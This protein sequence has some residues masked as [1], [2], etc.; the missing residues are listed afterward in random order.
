MLDELEIRLYLTRIG[1][2][3][4]FT[5]CEVPTIERL[6]ELQLAHLYHVPF[7]NLSITLKQ[8]IT[9]GGK[10]AYHKIVADNR[11]GF[12]Y[13]L[14]YAFYQLLSSLHFKVQMLSA[15]V[16]DHKN[17]T[18]GQPFDHL[19]LLVSFH[20]QQYLVDVGFG[21]SFIQPL[22]LS[23]E[24]IQQEHSIY[25][26]TKDNSTYYLSRQTIGEPIKRQ[27]RFTVAPRA[28]EDFGEMF[29]YHQTNANSTFT[30]KSVCSRLTDYGRVT[31][32]N[33]RL[34]RTEDNQKH[35]LPISNESQIRQVL[36]NEFGIYFSEQESLA[37]LLT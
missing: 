35:E 20:H 2:C 19:V 36:T 5:L 17:M 31:L 12:C 24:L 11:G 8:P 21:D 33:D 34:I 23:T 18:Y 15:E 30:Q 37:K 3:S 9:L 29:I 1:L 7:E 10:A 27:Y 32:S 26:L 16:F 14:N 22:C 28:I 4:S 25:H 6:N 13:E